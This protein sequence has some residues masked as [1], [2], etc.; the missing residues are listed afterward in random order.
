MNEERAF[1]V[2]VGGRDF[3]VSVRTR[4]FRE[5]GEAFVNLDGTIIRV[6]DLGLGEEALRERVVKEIERT[7]ER[8]DSAIVKK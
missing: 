6:A 2:Q 7:L 4:P 3:E 5:G 8:K 1:F